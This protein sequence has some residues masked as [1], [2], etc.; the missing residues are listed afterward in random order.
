MDVWVV[1]SSAYYES[2]VNL[3]WTLLCKP[4]FVY[5]VLFLLGQYLEVGLLCYK[6]SICLTLFIYT[7][8]YLA[9]R[10]LTCSSRGLFNCGI[11]DLVPWPGIKPRPPAL[12]A[13]TTWTT[14]EVPVFSFRRKV[15]EL[16]P[17]QFW[18]FLCLL[19][20]FP[21]GSVVKN[22]PAKWEVR[23]QSLGREDPL[24]MEMATIQYSGLRNPMDRGP[25]KR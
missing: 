7:F 23:V 13:W 15:I 14:R 6:E 5:I 8:I 25:F 10:G 11:W 16:F 3:L 19:S 12:R 2:W 22:L 21:G 4:S 1:S 18:I 24:E 20:G 9:A 17:K